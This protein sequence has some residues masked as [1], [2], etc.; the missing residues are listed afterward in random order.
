[1]CFVYIHVNTLITSLVNINSRENVYIASVY[2]V[3][4]GQQPNLVAIVRVIDVNQATNERQKITH[5]S[6]LNQP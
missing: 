2:L 5:C 4:K 3:L 6:W 1:M